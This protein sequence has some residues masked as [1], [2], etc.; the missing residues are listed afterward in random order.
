MPRREFLEAGQIVGTH[1]V[2]GELRVQPWC[3]SPE[4]FAR[5][6]TLYMDEQGTKPV[7]VRSRAHK[8]MALTLIEGIDTV[9]AA[10]ALRGRVLWLHRK[11]LKLPKG[12]Y[13][14]QD[15][16]GCRVI[17]AD[18]GEDYGPLTD[19]SNTGANDIY[20]LDHHGR[21]LLIPAI[22]DIVIR[23]QPDKDTVAI[24]PM[25]GLFDDAD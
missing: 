16:I 12:T 14:V 25:K 15:L 23:V 2:R 5:L 17:D 9:E 21:E 4:V 7:K 11:D 19:V 24:R 6:R 18:T 1:G 22:P 3:D 20:H 10:A 13:F 8:H